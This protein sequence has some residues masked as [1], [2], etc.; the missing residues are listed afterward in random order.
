MLSILLGTVTVALGIYGL[1]HWS[2]HV[3]VFL[4]AII[5]VSFICGGLIAILAGIS[6]LRK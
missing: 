4:K 5:P 3:L 6:S 1:L 2:S